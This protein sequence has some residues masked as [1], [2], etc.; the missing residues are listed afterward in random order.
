MSRRNVEVISCDWCGRDLVEKESSYF[1]NVNGEQNEEICSHCYHRLEMIRN[2]KETK[3]KQVSLNFNSFIETTLGEDAVAAY[4]EEWIKYG[5]E[6]KKLGE[7]WKTQLYDYCKTMAPAF[8]KIVC[9]YQGVAFPFEMRM[10]IEELREV[11]ESEN[12]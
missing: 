4:N 2:W 8:E 10:A 9:S 12:D 5:G 1:I 11:K 3:K 7:N 6:E